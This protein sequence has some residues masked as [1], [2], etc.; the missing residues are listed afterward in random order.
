M[1]KKSQLFFYGIGMF[2]IIFITT[3]ALLTPAKDITILARNESN[4]NCSDPNL[5][6]GLKATCI[7]VDWMPFAF[8]LSAMGVGMGYI[9]WKKIRG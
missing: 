5:S 2:V 7:E 1:S 8:F 6:T 3:V 9:T 4:L